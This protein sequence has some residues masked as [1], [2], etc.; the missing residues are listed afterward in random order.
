LIHFYKRKFLLETMETEEIRAP[1]LWRRPH[2]KI[3][4][5]NQEVSGN[6]YQPMIDYVDTKDRQGIFFERP[7]ES[8]S[9]P[10]PGEQ[11]L[12]KH[13]I[14][15]DVVS[16]VYKLDRCLVNAYSQQTKEMNGATVHTQ[17]LILRGSKENTALHPKLT[18]TMLR[19]HYVKELHLIK[20]RG[21]QGA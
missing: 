11:C 10:G 5:Y 14:S 1:V 8:I 9:L 7:K 4:S 2:A 6:F 19:D 12:R 17:N 3:Y 18:A 13:V 21:A 16:G 15:N 20:A